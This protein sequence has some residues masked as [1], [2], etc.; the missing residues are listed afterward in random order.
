MRCLARIIELSADVIQ[1]LTRKY[2]NISR[3]V[4]GLMSRGVM[5]ET[6]TKRIWDDGVSVGRSQGISIGQNQGKAQETIEFARELG[7]G[8]DKILERLKNKLGLS[9]E[10]AEKYI[11]DYGENET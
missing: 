11:K 10:Q 5:I 7:W 4:G 8:N 1:E 2:E 6:S 3:E 9:A